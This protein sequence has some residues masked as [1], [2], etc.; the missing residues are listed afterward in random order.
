MLLNLVDTLTVCPGNPDG[1]FLEM[2]DA[3]KGRFRSKTNETSA[4]VDMYA[5]VSLNGES[6]PHTIR[7]S[8][9]ELLIHGGKCVSCKTYR[10]QLRTMH[11]RWTARRDVEISKFTNDQ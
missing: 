7:T 5:T 4:F 3:R 1:H 6:Y 2:A 11:S 9:C 8:T 10:A